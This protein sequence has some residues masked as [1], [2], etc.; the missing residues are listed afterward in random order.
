[1]EILEKAIFAGAGIVGVL[2]LGGCIIYEASRIKKPYSEIPMNINGVCSAC[3]AYSS[4]YRTS[5]YAKVF[6]DKKYLYRHC[7]HNY[8]KGINMFTM[9]NN[10]VSVYVCKK[11]H[12]HLA[13][14]HDISVKTNGEPV[15]LSNIYGVYH[16]PQII[17]QTKTQ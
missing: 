1:M 14:L 5:I 7:K 2:Y 4:S 12:D 16:E 13:K 9:L 17:E 3:C 10:Y 15:Y 11:C 6:I 8:C